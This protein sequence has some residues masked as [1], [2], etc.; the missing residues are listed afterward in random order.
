MTIA[1]FLN[2]PPLLVEIGPDSLKARHGQDSVELP[3]EHGADG[4]LTTLGKEKTV[5]ALK[6]FLKAKSWLP[7]IRAWCAISSRGEKGLVI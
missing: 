5:A 4:R 3:L 2:P 1:S 6:N 7:R